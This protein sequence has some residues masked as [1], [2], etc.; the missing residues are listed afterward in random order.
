MYSSTERSRNRVWSMQTIVSNWIHPRIDTAV[1][2]S[3]LPCGGGSSRNRKLFRV[4]P[5]AIR[6]VPTK[7][8]TCSPSFPEDLSISGHV[9]LPSPVTGLMVN[10]STGI[11]LS[12]MCIG[13]EN[14]R[15]IIIGVFRGCEFGRVGSMVR[16]AVRKSGLGTMKRLGRDWEETRR[17]MEGT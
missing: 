13:G 15:S 5:T 7:G 4:A 14:C 8:E 2:Q 16:A 1:L 17:E 10:G 6:R 9:T 11:P 3:P 12:S